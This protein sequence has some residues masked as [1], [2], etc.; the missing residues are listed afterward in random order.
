MK[1]LTITVITDTHYYSEKNGVS[2]AAYER[3]NFKSQKL[4]KNSAAVLEAAYKQIAKDDRSDIVLLCGDVTNNGELNSHAE[5]IEQLRRLKAAGKRVYVITATHDYRENGVTAAYDGDREITTPTALR[6]DLFEMY[7]EFGP[8][9]ALAVH[10]A[11]MSYVVELNEDYCLFALNDDKNG[12]GKSGFSDECFDWIREQ[13]SAARERGQMIVAMTHHPLIAP[14]PLYGIIGKGDMLGDFDVRINQLADMGVQFIF[15]GHTH[16]HNISS[17]RSPR[18]N[19]IYDISTGSLVGY[20]AA[21]RSVTFDPDAG[22]VRVS[23]DLVAERVDAD[24]GGKTLREY[25][26]DQQIGM[27]RDMIRC[28]GEDID[29][30]ADMVTAISIKP[31]VIYRFA[32]LIKPVG[33]L[34]NSLRVGTVA[35]WSRAET[36]L[37]KEDYSDIKDAKVKDFVTELVMN[38]FAGESKY[39][40]DTAYYKITV[41]TL[42]IVDSVLRAL[43]VNIAK[44]LGVVPDVRSLIEP[45]LYNAGIP[46]YDAQ[47]EI[48]PFY[49]EDG[50]APEQEPQAVPQTVRESRKGRFIVAAAVVILILLLPLLPVAAAAVFIA[51]LINYFKYRD[52][53]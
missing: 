43:H 32:W 16:V 10:R 8:D 38:L 19:I 4:L 27:V 47:L 31:R 51:W 22:V 9:E 44:L 37:R 12:S 39:P 48:M 34:L 1:P 18:G 11:S 36:G 17:H 5:A 28:A 53:M 7:R 2:G 6:D 52:K 40:P 45:L 15:T 23:T 21:M 30:L 33:K 26:E 41:G 42:N 13:V 24:L 20:P 3:A 29:K 50:K 35:S 46:A 49:T 25:L 14:S